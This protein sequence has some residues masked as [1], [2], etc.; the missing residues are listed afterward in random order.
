VP[1]LGSPKQTITVT[2]GG[3][4]RGTTAPITVNAL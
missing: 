3:G 2:D 1:L 4:L